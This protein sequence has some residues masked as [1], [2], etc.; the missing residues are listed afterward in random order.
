MEK[1]VYKKRAIIIAVIELVISVLFKLIGL[2]NLF[3]AVAYSFAVLSVMLIAGKVKN[4]WLAAT[5][6]DDD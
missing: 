3:I 6:G 2:D 1:R 4:H 5:F